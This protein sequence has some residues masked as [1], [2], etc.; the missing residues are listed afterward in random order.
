MA[1]GVGTYLLLGDDSNILEVCM[2]L[3]P[4]ASSTIVFTDHTCASNANT[5]TQFVVHSDVVSGKGSAQFLDAKGHAHFR[6]PLHQ[7]KSLWFMGD[8]IIFPTMDSP[9]TSKLNAHQFS[10]LWSLRLG[11]P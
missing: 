4:T 3:C 2:F 5:Y 7:D 11:S 9:T 6:I 10:E 1:V 8:S